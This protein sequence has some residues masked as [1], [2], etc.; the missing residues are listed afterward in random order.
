MLQILQKKFFLQKTQIFLQ[1]MQFFLQKTQIF[2]R[3]RR[4]PV[5]NVVFPAENVVFPIENVVFPVENVAFPIENKFREQERPVQS[6]LVS[7]SFKELKRQAC[8]FSRPHCK[9]MT[10]QLLQFSRRKSHTKSCKWSSRNS[11]RCR[12]RSLDVRESSSKMM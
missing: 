11:P 12:R 1:K 2:C 7:F 8:Y 3:K 9:M 10:F 6:L 4:F 5:E